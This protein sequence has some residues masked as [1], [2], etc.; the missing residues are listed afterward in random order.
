MGNELKKNRG[1][2]DPRAGGISGV[3]FLA[4]TVLNGLIAAVEVAGGVLSG[5]LALLSDAAHNLGDTAAVAF[6]YAAWRI[7]GRGSDARRTYGYKRAEIIAAFVNAAALAAI[8]LF[9]V[10]EALRRLHRPQAIDGGLMLLVAAVGLA[11]NLAAML[12]LRTDAGN[13]MNVRSGYLHLLGDTVSS[14]G[15]ILG[16][17]L[18]RAWGAFWIDPLVTILISIYLLRESWAIVRGS[19]GILMQSAARLD[20]DA[21]RRDVEAI[22]EVGNIHHVHT[23]MSNEDTVYFEAHVDVDDRPLS[24]ACAIAERIENLLKEKYGVAHVTLQFETGRCQE[25]E[26]FKVDRRATKKGGAAG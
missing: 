26:F 3:R 5:S 15:V 17:I 25:K 8:S 20:Y 14:L 12:L 19:V 22:P 4:A 7:A 9:L 23:W 24:Q 2:H 13:S 1:G 10:V 6:S 18:I 11:A 21:M 16:A